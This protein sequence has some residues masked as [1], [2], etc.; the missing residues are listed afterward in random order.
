MEG[1]PRPVRGKWPTLVAVGAVVAPVAAVL[2]LG[3]TLTI[4]SPSL[5]FAVVKIVFT[6]IAVVTAIAGARWATAA[7]T[8]LLIE[9]LA[10]VVW[11]TLKVEHYP[12]HGAL[13][14]ALMLAVPL[15][16][17]GILFVLAGGIRAGTWPRARFTGGTSGQPD[18]PGVSHAPRDARD[19]R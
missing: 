14:T 9:A 3:V 17:S 1:S 18:P 4:T 19:P 2:W 12:P 5:T 15:A 16:V 7:G 6:I 11:I 13:R 8:A 10:V